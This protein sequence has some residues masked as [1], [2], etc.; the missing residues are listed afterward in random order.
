MVT[1]SS[2]RLAEQLQELHLVRVEHVSGLA[3]DVGGA[4]GGDSAGKRG[5]ESEF[6]ELG[7]DGVRCGV[8]VH[9]YRSCR[10]IRR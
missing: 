6:T 9:Q 5:R 4:E 10:S 7:L 8:V 1:H 2:E 3:D